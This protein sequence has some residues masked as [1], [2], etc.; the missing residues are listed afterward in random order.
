MRC[1]NKNTKTKQPTIQMRSNTIVH[2]L[3][4]FLVTFCPSSVES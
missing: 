2:F 1:F 4:L 3:P